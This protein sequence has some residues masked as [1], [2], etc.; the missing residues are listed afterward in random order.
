M[1]GIRRYF[2]SIPVM[3]PTAGFI[4]GQLTGLLGRKG[5]KLRPRALNLTLSAYMHLSFIVD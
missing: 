4:N 2:F 5:A 1:A 3:P